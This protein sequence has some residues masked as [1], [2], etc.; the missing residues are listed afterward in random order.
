MDFNKLKRVQDIAL[1]EEDCRTKMGE[2][3]MQD[4][5]RATRE[6][7]RWRREREIEKR[8]RETEKR[9]RETERRGRERGMI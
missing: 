2:N 1:E 3:E 7:E 6:R 5:S 8:E 9:E 4:N